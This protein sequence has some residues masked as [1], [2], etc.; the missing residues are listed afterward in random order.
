MKNDQIQWAASIT[1]AAKITGTS[2]QSLHAYKRDGCPA[3][4]TNGK[5]NLV[6]LDT[7]TEVHGKRTAPETDEMRVERLRILRATAERIERENDERAGLTVLRSEAVERIRAGMSTVFH[8]LDRIFC[9][10]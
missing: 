9:N 8:E 7:W 5:V 4:K 2:R 3:F 1:E 10:E 6:E